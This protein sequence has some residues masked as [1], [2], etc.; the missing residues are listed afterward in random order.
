MTWPL[1]CF[2]LFGAAFGWLSFAHRHRFSEGVTPPQAGDAVG[3]QWPARLAWLALCTL[4][5]PL[6]M[7]TGAA[8]A[9]LRPRASAQPAQRPQGANHPD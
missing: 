9:L 2:L 3:M 6:L 1:A 8:G 7:L 4:L 5:W